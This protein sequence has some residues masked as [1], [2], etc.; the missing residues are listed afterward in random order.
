MI[1]NRGAGKAPKI[2]PFSSMHVLSEQNQLNIPMCT[3]TCL[4]STVVPNKTLTQSHRESTPDI[5]PTQKVKLF[6]INSGL[7]HHAD[8]AT[9]TILHTE[10]MGTPN[11]PRRPTQT[12]FFFS[13][14][15]VFTRP[16]GIRTRSETQSWRRPMQTFINTF[17]HKILQSQLFTR[18][19]AETQSLCRIRH[20]VEI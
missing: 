17:S 19:L 9:I 6:N 16:F 10:S 1:A 18:G 14:I 3:H 7:G 12:W 4:W 11:A 15:L 2:I 20:A 13:H 8:Y 5:P